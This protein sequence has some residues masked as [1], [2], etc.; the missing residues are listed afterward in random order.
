MRNTIKNK[1]KGVL[2]LPFYTILLI[3]N[4][5]NIL[6][7]LSS[8]IL[9]ILLIRDW[10]VYRKTKKGLARSYNAAR[11]E[12][13]YFSYITGE[14]GAG[15]TTFGAGILQVFQQVIIDKAHEEIE[16]CKR[17]IYDFD[18]VELNKFIAANH[19]NYSY[20]EIYLMFINSE[21]YKNYQDLVYDD[22]INK[23]SFSR[24]FF[25]YIR[26]YYR[27]LD[28]NFVMANIDVESRI[29]G[30][31][32]KVLKK[33]FLKIKDSP[34]PI[35]L[36]NVLFYDETTLDENN[37]HNNEIVA[38]DDGQTE[39]L[40]LIR[41]F[42]EET[43][44]LLLTAQNMSRD[45]LQWRELANTEINILGRQVKKNFITK[46]YIY[47]IKSKL[48]SCEKKM[49]KNLFVIDEYRFDN[50]YNRF[51]KREFKLMTKIDKVNSKAFLKY[52]C[53]IK[54]KGKKE[55][56]E[57]I[58]MLPIN[59][60][61]GTTDTHHFK[62]I[63][64]YIKMEQKLSY[65]DLKVAEELT[66]EE[67][68]NIAKELLKSKKREKVE[69]KTRAERSEENRRKHAE[70]QAQKEAARKENKNAAEESTANANLSSNENGEV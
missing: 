15:K 46:S 7:I 28:N 35:E 37:T 40:R 61:Y 41:H 58:I 39:F 62:F 43:M 2:Q 56:Y 23:N 47:S 24:L 53:C 10:F 4:R 60:C 64:E 33:E 25:K 5:T 49:Y 69:K 57:D 30:N 66:W 65:Y 44:Y 16:K 11:Y 8:P 18:Y 59:Y 38:V 55:T 29:T 13:G 32:N 26:A 67:K 68:C 14:L 22:G 36:F 21:I 27:L 20:E 12:F 48:L 6:I 3:I 63:L 45:V 70:A 31:Y 51:K 50:T 42:G 1:I 9:L 19:E 52:Y 17:I 54:L 34:C